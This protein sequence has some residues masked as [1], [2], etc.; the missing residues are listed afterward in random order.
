MLI[1]RTGSSIFETEIDEQTIFS[2][3]LLGEE[4]IVSSFLSPVDVT[5][6][7]GD[8]VLLNSK[9]YEIVGEI[10]KQQLQNSLFK[11][12]IEFYS[13]VYKLYNSLIKHL[14][15]TKFSYF[16]TPSELLS[17]IVSNM[18]E[19]WYVG[20]APA[21]EPQ[22]FEFKDMSCRVALSDIASKFQLEYYVDNQNVYLVESAGSIKGVELGYGK[23]Q[24]AYDIT[25]QNATSSYATVWYAFG[26]SQN[27]PAGYRD[28]QDRLTLNSPIEVNV[29]LYGR[30]EGVIEY[31][32]IYPHR[33]G[34]ITNVVSATVVIDSTLDFNLNEQNIT[35]AQAKIVFQSGELNGQEFF[36]TKYDS[37]TKQITF[38]T[39]KDETGYETPNS[40]FAVAVGDRYTL[41]GITMPTSY[42]TAAETELYNTALAYATQNSRP[43]FSINVNVDE[44]Y[45]RENG[46][47]YALEAGDKIT[48]TA[49]KL[50]YSGLIR[51]QS[52]SYPLVN[53]NKLTLTLSNTVN[54]SVSEQLVKDSK[55]QKKNI[56]TLR[57]GYNGL[58][59]KLGWK[60][61]QE[62]LNMTFDPDGYFDAEKIKPLSIETG[63]LVV[64]AKSQQFLLE[65]IMQPNFEGNANVFQVSDGVLV[66]GT[67][68]ETI[69]EWQITG[70][71][72][73]VEDNNA[74]YIYAKCNKTDY[75]DAHIIL[76]T[77]QIK[78]NDNALYY[79]F[80]VGVLH[81]VMEGVRWISLSYGTTSINGRF[82]KTGRIQDASGD[83]YFDLDEGT[84]KGK[85]TFIN[86]D[87][88]YED[89][90][91]LADKSATH[92]TT[93]PTPPYKIGDIWTDGSF[94]YRCITKRLA[95]DDFHTEDW[96]DATEYDS[97]QTVIDGGLVTSGTIQVAGDSTIKAGM[98]G[99]GTDETSVRFWAGDTYGNRG[100][101]PF[102][103]L[104][105]GVVYALN[106]VIQGVINATEGSFGVLSI[107]GNSIINDFNSL[108]QIVLRNDAEA[109]FSAFGTNVKPAT[110]PDR[111]GLI[112]EQKKADGGWNIGAELRAANS[113]DRNVALWVPEGEALLEQATIN[114]R[115][116]VSSVL[117]NQNIAID[118]SK[119]DLISILSVGGASGTNFTG[120]VKAGK[121]VKVVNLSTDRS[122]Y[123]YNTIRGYTSVEIPAS[124]AVTTVFTGTYWYVC[125]QNF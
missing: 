26:G 112:I 65:V 125:G 107:L 48:I 113:T 115:S 78:P 44:K 124:G 90:A 62:L 52:I 60:T 98:T 114:G 84:I 35:D 95:G 24:G 97:T 29:E 38:Q 91:D 64:G 37:A 61:T 43:Q 3:T 106:A 2:Q 42:I 32:F 105:N 74:R 22:L 86:S 94:F 66:H 83:T 80:W 121:E 85:I 88:E 16:G 23:N 81:S 17:L 92:F 19:G 15:R 79:H 63:M 108:A 21:L 68:E 39:N 58:K 13:E 117:N 5:F 20:G 110:S 45:I 77:D 8:Y 93:T 31:D 1:Y 53:P 71:T 123:I 104:Q 27:L 36:I 75:N 118:V 103:V 120:S 69:R 111:A 87:N 34:T 14:G 11:Y 4:K 6:Q 70:Q 9:K 56:V 96:E 59:V 47:A 18:G 49:P 122:I 100:T 10:N 109:Q 33:T 28:G 89:I 57:K 67:I 46:Y 76:S 50:N 119:A 72:I 101:A 30:K 54:Y 102:R 7:I 12:D 51:I 82:I 99:N 41:V 55:E 25:R 40:T 73:T 116:A